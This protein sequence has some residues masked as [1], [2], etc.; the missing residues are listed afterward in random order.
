V[1]K[2][3]HLPI[4][5]GV[6]LAV[7]SHGHVQNSTPPPPPQVGQKG[8]VGIWYGSSHCSHSQSTELN[9]KKNSLL[10]F[11]PM[12]YEE[13]GHLKTFLDNLWYTLVSQ[14]QQ[15]SLLPMEH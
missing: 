2:V 7:A 3:L 15:L 10:E 13:N 1:D 9:F 4:D 14:K 12:F 8:D 11:F 5:G 6:H